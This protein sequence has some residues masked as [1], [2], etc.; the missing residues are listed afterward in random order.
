LRRFH[1]TSRYA[2]VNCA[3]GNQRLKPIDA[4][5]LRSG[6][7]S[8]EVGSAYFVAL[9]LSLTL[10]RDTRTT[11]PRSSCPLKHSEIVVLR[12]A[13]CMKA[14]V[15]STPMQPE[16]IH[17]QLWVHRQGRG[18]HP[19]LIRPQRCR[20]CHECWSTRWCPVVFFVHQ[21]HEVK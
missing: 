9:S 7:P 1:H 2:S 3:R 14:Y 13:L 4:G 18:K 5:F 6:A 12:G 10:H 11:I 15:Q 21:L 16:S 20:H 17:R 8:Y 19:Q